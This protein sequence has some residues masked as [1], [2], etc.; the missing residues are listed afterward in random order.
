MHCSHQT[1]HPTDN[2]KLRATG[3]TEAAH[4]MFAVASDD[5]GLAHGLPEG[6][7]F[8]VSY[9]TAAS[10]SLVGHG[11]LFYSGSSGLLDGPG[12]WFEDNRLDSGAFLFISV[13]GWLERSPLCHS[14]ISTVP[15]AA[16]A[17]LAVSTASQAILHCSNKVIMGQLSCRRRQ[18]VVQAT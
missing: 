9:A 13:R 18:S 7:C 14:Q 15:G 12:Q 11:R 8:V 6:S 2:D 1:R 4:A 5:K 3:T 10:V 16:A 17:T